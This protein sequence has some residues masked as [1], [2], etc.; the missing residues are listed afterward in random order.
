MRTKNFIIV[1]AFAVTSV[2]CQTTERHIECTSDCFGQIIE[3]FADGMDLFADG[4]ELFAEAMEDVAE[5]AA[6]DSIVTDSTLTIRSRN[7]IVTYNIKG[8][9]SKVV[10]ISKK[11]R[12]VTRRFNVGEFHGI[13][14]NHSFQVV[15]C[16][17]VDHVVVR[18][19]EKLNQYLNVRLSKG[20]LVVKLSNIHTIE[21]SDNARCGYVYLPYNLKLDNIALSGVATFSTELPI[22]VTTMS[23]DLSGASRCH[24]GKGVTCRSFD[25]DLSG[26][27]K[28]ACNVNS[29]K[30][31]MEMSGAS[32][33]EGALKGS[34]AD[35]ELSGTAKLIAPRTDVRTLDVDMSGASRLVLEGKASTMEIDLSGTA[36]IDASKMNV[37]NVSGDMS[38]ASNATVN[39]SRAVSVDLTG[40]SSLNCVGNADLSRSTASRAASVRRVSKGR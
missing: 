33:Y 28:V 20:N 19:N 15:M 24:F 31:T 9:N 14:V 2:S 34:D 36:A 1:M 6:A 26:T 16:D 17:T 32:R 23:L 7:G 12:Y 5:R 4:M 38:G 8:S 27:A 40:T 18:I 21:S 13:D 30:L 10:R 39:A 11:D 37:D 35:I 29:K 25:V 3:A 22:A